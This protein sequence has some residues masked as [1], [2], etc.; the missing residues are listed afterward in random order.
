MKLIDDAGGGRVP[1]HTVGILEGR[2]VEGAVLSAG[3]RLFHGGGVTV[4][5]TLDG[6]SGDLVAGAEFDAVEGASADV[7]AGRDTGIGIGSVGVEGYVEG[8]PIGAVTVIVA[9]VLRIEDACKVFRTT[10]RDIEEVLT[11]YLYR[12]RDVDVY[13]RGTA[14]GIDC[15][16]VQRTD[17]CRTVFL[18]RK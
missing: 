4:G 1:R 7:A 12:S 10:A 5:G 6:V 8:L 16:P 3:N 2:K 15:H 18:G 13:A 17:N 11:V 9:T 14:V